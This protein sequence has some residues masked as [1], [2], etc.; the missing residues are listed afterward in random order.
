MK[1]FT[2]N[3]THIY[4]CLIILHNL[5]HTHRLKKLQK[6]THTLKVWCSITYNFGLVSLRKL[7]FL[8]KKSTQNRSRVMRKHVVGIANQGQ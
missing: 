4:Y 7:G 6:K 8:R 2:K 5:L 3:W 1:H